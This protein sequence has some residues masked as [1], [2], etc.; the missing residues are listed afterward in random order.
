MVI[1]GARH[2]PSRRLRPQRSRLLQ[3]VY[4]RKDPNSVKE[5]VWLPIE[6]FSL[7]FLLILQSLKL[8]SLLA[9]RF[10]QMGSYEPLNTISNSNPTAPLT[11]PSRLLSPHD[12]LQLPISIRLLRL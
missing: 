10:F 7:R 11:H 1:Q 8:N 2:H 9:V 5:P 12:P 4:P 6:W 3:R